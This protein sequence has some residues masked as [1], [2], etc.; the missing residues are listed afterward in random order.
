MLWRG[1]SSSLSLR[2]MMSACGGAAGGIMGCLMGGA[3]GMG[4][5]HQML[6]ALDSVRYP[7]CRNPN[8][9]LRSPNI[10]FSGLVSSLATSCRKI[11]LFEKMRCALR[12]S[13]LAYRRYSATV[14]VL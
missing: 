5:S 7:A 11:P 13:R 9:S 14:M 12:N 4:R 8:R 3:R 1:C 10:A 2:L 6:S